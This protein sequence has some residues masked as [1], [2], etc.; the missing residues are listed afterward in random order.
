MSKKYNIEEKLLTQVTAA[1]K[2]YSGFGI[3]KT[4]YRQTIFIYM[5]WMRKIMS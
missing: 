3:E 1:S 4:N 2:R 5:S